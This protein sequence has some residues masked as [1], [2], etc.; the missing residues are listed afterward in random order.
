MLRFWAYHDNRCE[1]GGLLRQYLFHYYLAEDM[2]EIKEI[3]DPNG[4]V[5]GAVTFLGK[6]K[7]LKD[8]KDLVPIVGIKEEVN[9]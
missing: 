9:K 1:Y 3:T 8:Y 6:S 7:L 4:G 2:V 5:R